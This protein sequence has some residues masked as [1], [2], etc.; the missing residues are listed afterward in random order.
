MNKYIVLNPNLIELKRF[1]RKR[2][3]INYCNIMVV[4]FGIF[5]TIKETFV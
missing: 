2:E 4:Q 1:T 3:A 5:C